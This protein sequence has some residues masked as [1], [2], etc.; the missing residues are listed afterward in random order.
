M[1][2]ALKG[3][4]LGAVAAVYEGGMA[5]LGKQGA[6]DGFRATFDEYYGK[7]FQK[8]YKYCDGIKG[9]HGDQVSKNKYIQTVCSDFDSKSWLNFRSFLNGGCNIPIN[10]SDSSRGMKDSVL[11]QTL[12]SKSS[13][14]M[15]GNN[16]PGGIASPMG[17]TSSLLSFLTDSGKGSEKLITFGA[18]APVTLSWA[19]TIQDSMEFVNELEGTLANEMKVT[20]F[21]QFNLGGFIIPGPLSAGSVSDSIQKPGIKITQRSENKHDVMRTMIID[22]SDDDMGELPCL[23]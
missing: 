19:T 18:N 21:D 23:R 17:S 14:I 12:C 2:G 16:V 22:F 20:S 15:N 8:L 4:A 10:P 5:A 6:M 9:M 13:T 1:A 3:I 11:F 7:A